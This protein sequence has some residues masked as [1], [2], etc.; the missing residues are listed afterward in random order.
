M[1]KQQPASSLRWLNSALKLL[2]QVKATQSVGS[3]HAGIRGGVPGSN[4]IWGWYLRLTYPN[5][6]AKFFADALME[7]EGVL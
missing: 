3:R 7:T 6:A 1:D 4:P 5:W 2:D